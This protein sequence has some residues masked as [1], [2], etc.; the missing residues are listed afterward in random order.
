MLEFYFDKYK[1]S[2]NK[3]DIKNIAIQ[4]GLKKI[5]L[6]EEFFVKLH[7]RYSPS[8]KDAIILPLIIPLLEVDIS[9]RIDNFKKLFEKS[10]F[11]REIWV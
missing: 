7:G 8:S 6:N 4:I 10:R 11:Q 9:K 5:I 2:V 3:D 1:R